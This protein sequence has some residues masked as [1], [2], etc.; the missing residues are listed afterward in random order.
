MKIRSV[1]LHLAAFVT[2]IFP[3]SASII[4]FCKPRFSTSSAESQY[5]FVMNPYRSNIFST[6]FINIRFKS[7]GSVPSASCHSEDST[8]SFSYPWVIPDATKA[9]PEPLPPKSTPIFSSMNS[10]RFAMSIVSSNG[11]MYSSSSAAME[12]ASLTYIR[13]SAI[14]L[15]PSISRMYQMLSLSYWLTISAIL[16]F[17]MLIFSKILKCS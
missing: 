9:W 14:L 2:L 12:V 5:T 15:L 10:P 13:P 1:I 16:C 3:S 7:S 6:N 4:A 11:A 17:G 8:Y